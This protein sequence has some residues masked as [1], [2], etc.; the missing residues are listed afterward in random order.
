MLIID[1]AYDLKIDLPGVTG[2]IEVINYR[3]EVL[4]IVEFAE[5][6]D[7]NI[8]IDNVYNRAGESIMSLIEDNTFILEEL[9]SECFM[10]MAIS[11]AQ[12]G[13]YYESLGKVG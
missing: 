6:F 7:S 13:A 12:A 9:A 2:F 4:L 8:Q 3:D 1:N 5:D 10:R 11:R